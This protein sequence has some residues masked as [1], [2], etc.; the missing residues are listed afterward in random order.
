MIKLSYAA[1]INVP[2]KYLGKDITNLIAKID[3]NS[4]DNLTIPVTANIGGDYA[5]PVVTTDL[6]SGIKS[7]TTKLVEI[8]KQ[9]LI[10]KGKDK[11][12][13]LIGGL[14]SGNQKAKDST[15]ATNK[16]TDAVKDVLG[17]L[18]G[19]KKKDSTTVKKDSTVT[20]NDAV[21][22]AAKSV[23][24]GLLNKKKKTE[25]KKDSAN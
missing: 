12:T 6:S 19:N 1:I 10:T 3:D 21:K 4:L 25:V 9:K 22:D 7:L 11:A 20:K 14:L 24:G 18:L 23:L 17:G 2:A 16:N 13:D 8:E 5:S 15:V